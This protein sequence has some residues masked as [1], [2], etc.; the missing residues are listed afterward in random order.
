MTL[1]IAGYVSD[2]TYASTDLQPTDQSF[3]LW[4]SRGI[5]DVPS[6]RG[7]DVVVPHKIGQT[8]GTRRADKLAI[9]LTG[10]VLANGA[11]ADLL[12]AAFREIVESLKALF[13]PADGYQT[14][15]ATLE[16]GSEAMI[17]ARVVGLVITEQVPSHVAS[18]P[19]TLGITPAGS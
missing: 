9:E 5:N 1:S 11:T 13:D 19:V 3:V 14:L 15:A 17:A 16:D 8:A 6:V 12:V 18:A 10:W 7:T 2:L 4:I